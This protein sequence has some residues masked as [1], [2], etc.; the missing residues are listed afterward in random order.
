[1]KINTKSWHYKFNYY[2]NNIDNYKMPNT[3]CGYFWRSVLN[4]IRILI[5]G[6]TMMLIGIFLLSPLINL[7]IT[8]SGLSY[9]SHIALGLYGIVIFLTVI[10]LSRKTSFGRIVFEY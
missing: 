3:V 7:L 6:L 8:D 9:M 4:I 10:G 2:W 5:M 1:M